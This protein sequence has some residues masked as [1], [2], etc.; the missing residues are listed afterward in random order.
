ME[1]PEQMDKRRA[2][3]TWDFV[4]DDADPSFDELNDE[5]RDAALECAA[6]WRASDASAGIVA[7]PVELLERA[8]DTISRYS[9]SHRMGAHADMA[10]L[11]ELSEAIRAAQGESADG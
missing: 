1:T 8:K 5:A 6:Q 9:G 2:Q 11:R 4:R 10:I 7:V 3:V